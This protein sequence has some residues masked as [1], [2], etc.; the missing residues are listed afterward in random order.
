LP[1]FVLRAGAFFQ[2]GQQVER[3]AV[4]ADFFAQKPKLVIGLLEAKAVSEQRRFQRQNT[5]SGSPALAAL[6]AA[7]SLPGPGKSCINPGIRR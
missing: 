6:A 7:F 2:I 5:S 3:L 4:D 1:D